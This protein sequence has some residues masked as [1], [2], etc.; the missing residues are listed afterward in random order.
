MLEQVLAD[1]HVPRHGRGRPRT[2]PDAVI[3]DKAYSSGT[4]RR[5]LRN[6][7]IAAEILSRPEYL[8]LPAETLE[9]SLTDRT[10][11]VL[12]PPPGPFFT[13]HDG[14]ASFPWRSTGALIAAQLA[15][16]FDLPQEPAGRAGAAIFRTD[17]YRKHMR[18][19]GA[20]LPGASMKVEGTLSHP[21]PV[22]SERGTMI[23]GPDRFFDDWVFEP[24]AD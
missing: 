22:A 23:L 17:L 18:A 5:Q 10:A 21:L 3:A 1:I 7:G 4:I 11:F 8:G 13:F 14:A 24:P 16:R 12:A 19:A 20:D 6:R 9:A 2:R 15:R